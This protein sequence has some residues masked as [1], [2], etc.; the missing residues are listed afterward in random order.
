MGPDVLLARMSMLKQHEAALNSANSFAEL[1]VVRAPTVSAL[2]EWAATADGGR[3]A[4]SRSAF[5]QRLGIH[6]CSVRPGEA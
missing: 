3:F 1:S 2:R 6:L 5:V 4:A